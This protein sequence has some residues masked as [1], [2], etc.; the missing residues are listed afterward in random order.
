MKF[1][2]VLEKRRSIRRYKD[3]PVPQ[4]KI[5]EILEAAR[6]SPSAGHRQPCIS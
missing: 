6:I 2:E 5:L 4:E 1:R 3:T